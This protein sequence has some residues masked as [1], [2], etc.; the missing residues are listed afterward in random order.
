MVSFKATELLLHKVGIRKTNVMRIDYRGS[1][2]PGKIRIRIVGGKI[3]LD[4]H[5]SL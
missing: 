5:N 4:V 1:G 3:S 2:W